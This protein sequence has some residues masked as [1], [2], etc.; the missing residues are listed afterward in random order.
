MQPVYRC[1]RKL[2]AVDV[3]LGVGCEVFSFSLH[4]LGAIWLYLEL[5]VRNGNLQSEL[6]AQRFAV[7]QAV[8]F[9][10]T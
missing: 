5:V 10:T 3:E 7:G 1:G 2:A 9:S 8:F 4:Q 6:H